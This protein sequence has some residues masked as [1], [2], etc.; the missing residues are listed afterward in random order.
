MSNN[1]APGAADTLSWITPVSLILLLIY[2]L[3]CVALSILRG[4]YGFLAAVGG[5][6]ITIA[7]S[8]ILIAPRIVKF[9]DAKK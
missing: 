6:I 5:W 4:D 1:A 7:V 2:I 8:I 9:L 3:G